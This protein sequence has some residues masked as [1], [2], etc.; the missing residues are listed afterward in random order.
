[1]TEIQYKIRHKTSK[2]YS[3]GNLYNGWNAKGKTWTSIS[4]L[5]SYLTRC[6]NDDYMRSKFGDWEIV[7]FH[8]QQVAVRGLIDV[9]KPEKI[10]ELLKR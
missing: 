10:M 4:Q 6:M 2:L 3:K 5:R 8:V 9:V 1:M 7:E